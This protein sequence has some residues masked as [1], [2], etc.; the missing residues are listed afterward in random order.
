HIRAHNGE[1]PFRCKA[2]DCPKSFGQRRDMTRHYNSVHLDLKVW[3]IYHMRLRHSFR[4]FPL[5]QKNKQQLVLDR[6]SSC[7]QS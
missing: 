2:P 4:D 7:Y 6:Y 5:S 1:K 3:A